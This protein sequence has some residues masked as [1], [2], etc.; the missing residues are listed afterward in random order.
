MENIDT[1][2]FI[3]YTIAFMMLCYG[4]NVLLVM[5]K[6]YYYNKQKKE[7]EGIKERFKRDYSG[8]LITTGRTE[9]CRRNITDEVKDF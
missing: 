3:L 9:P 7:N 5:I 8:C 6:D 1:I 2:D 4:F